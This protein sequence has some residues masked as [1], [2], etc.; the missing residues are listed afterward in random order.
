[1]SEG[2]EIQY[3]SVPQ[4]VSWII[5]LWDYRD[6]D[7]FHDLTD[8]IRFKGPKRFN[9]ALRSFTRAISKGDAVG[10]RFYIGTEI[11]SGTA[12]VLSP[13]SREQTLEILSEA[14]FL[15][16]RGVVPWGQLIA[17]LE[18]IREAVL[19]SDGEEEV[20]FGFSPIVYDGSDRYKRAPT[21][22]IAEQLNEE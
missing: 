22:W 18:A 8:S 15:A 13:D 5:P 7:E 17:Q 14:Q 1:M 4:C 10:V 3:S 12:L 19:A 16:S 6:R 2:S 11:P 9:D 20:S 21:N